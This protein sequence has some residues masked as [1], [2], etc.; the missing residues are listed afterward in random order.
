[1]TTI[2]GKLSATQAG[3]GTVYS[4]TSRRSKGSRSIL[5]ARLS[6]LTDKGSIGQSETYTPVYS[7]DIARQ[8]EINHDPG[9]H[10]TD[11]P[12]QVSY[13]KYFYNQSCRYSNSLGQ[14]CG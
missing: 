11:G 14:V 10:G 4:H 5:N 8:Y 2:P 3:D 7:D 13:P 1:M 9:V 12:V 6:S